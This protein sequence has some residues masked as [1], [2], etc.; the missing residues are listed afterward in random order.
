MNA[1]IYI[2]ATWL[3]KLYLAIG[4]LIATSTYIGQRMD[5]VFSFTTFDNVIMWIMIASMAYM[6]LFALYLFGRAIYN[7]VKPLFKKK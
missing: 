6:T 5:H 3:G 7:V 1:L 4:L 2:K